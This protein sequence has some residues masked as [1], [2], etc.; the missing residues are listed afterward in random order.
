MPQLL[1][2]LLS[3]TIGALISAFLSYHVR[4]RA[5]RKE[6]SERKKKLALV[7][8]LQL[9]NF[10]AADFYCT[11]L[12]K[13]LAK[14]G[15]I[16]AEKE[17]DF[18]HELSVLLSDQIAKSDPAALTKAHQRL[19][20]YLKGIAPSIDRF[21]VTAE[22]LSEMSEVTIYAYTR[23]VQLGDRLKAAATTIEHW[24]EKADPTLLDAKTILAAY[25]TYRDFADAA[26]VLRAAFVTNAGVTKAYSQR[27]LMR[28]YTAVQKEVARSFAV[29][30]KLSNAEAAA[31]ATRAASE[32]IEERA[33][34]ATPASIPQAA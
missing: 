4:L 20:P 12:V 24:L 1:V 15:W 32:V 13:N 2:A 25:Q 26:G 10:V 23:Y 19:S 28:G 21:N 27:C 5:K 34:D 18:E 17:F 11:E 7:H 29:G 16:K 33:G 8:F 14:A 3:G 6:D 31:A 9:T 22:D 30:Q